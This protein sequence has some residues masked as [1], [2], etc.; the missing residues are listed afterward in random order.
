MIMTCEMNFVGNYPL[1]LVFSFFCRGLPVYRVFLFVNN[2]PQ[3]SPIAAAL[4]R[5]R[6]FFG[7]FVNH[8]VDKRLFFLY[9]L[10]I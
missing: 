5:R 2:F 8:F 10:E 4:K 9:N 6:S 1:L 3:A 7:G